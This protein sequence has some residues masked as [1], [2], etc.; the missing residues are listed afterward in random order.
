MFGRTP[1]VIVFIAVLLAVIG[2]PCS[3]T[4]ADDSHP[5]VL[6]IITDE[7]NFRTLGCYRK[8]LPPVQA[9]MWGKNAIV[10]TLN[11]DRLADEGLIGTRA[12]ATAP[13]C[14]PSRAAMITGRYP[15]NT[16]APQ[17]NMI[18]DRSIPTLADR[19]NEAGYRTSFIGKWHLGGAGK[20]E[21]A[22]KID[23]GF[24]N[25]DFMFNRGHW[26]KFEI[27]DG[28]PRVAARKNGQPNYNVDG[29]DE[30]SF[31][32]DWLTDRAL[33]F[34]SQPSESPFFAVISY[35]D[36]HGP[37][38]VRE[39]YDHRFD[40]LPFMPPRTYETGI[41]PPGWLGGGSK[42]PLF[43][44][45]DMSRYFGM[46][47]CIDD[48]FGRLL[49]KLDQLDQLDNT[50]IVMTSDHGDLCYEHDRQ[51][52]GNP[53]EGS[54]RVPLL[55]RL[56]AKIKAG[57]VYRHPV[58]T[59]DITP[60]VMG[61]LEL[62]SESGDEGRDLSSG[63]TDPKRAAGETITFLR[64]AGTKAAWVAAVDDRYKLILSISDRPWLFDNEQDPDELLN[65]YRRPGTEGVAE[66]LAKELVKYGER[67]D[68][69]YLNDPKI[70]QALN[71]IL[72]PASTSTTSSTE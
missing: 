64:N 63:F 54:A 37:N 24:D 15:H 6:L 16:G 67:T 10:E 17:N 65:Y 18:L 4:V 23:G 61:L 1:S 71:Q 45:P 5:N 2:K 58:G 72:G 39:P 49:A 11:L 20:P 47:Q 28:K 27:L 3:F 38:T 68:D 53:Y 33:D 32:T 57:T 29:A 8:L 21:W 12:Y 25:K 26:K 59:V 70:Q 50:L 9:E 44:G 13:V 46:V 40:D 31:A 42:H 51:N 19:L 41:E 34:I 66:R 36:P 35:P 7:H 62:P 14:T 56:P 43:K 48:N 22:P 55:M 30:Q 60:T 69:P 52:K